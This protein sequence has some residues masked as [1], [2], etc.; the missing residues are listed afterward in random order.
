MKVS[1]I[2]FNYYNGLHQRFKELFAKVLKDFDENAIHG[3]RVNMKKQVAFFRLLAGIDP[4]FRADKA[5]TLFF[6]IFKN[7]GAIRKIHI[8]K[9]ILTNKDLN[10]NVGAD[11]IE[12]LE[13]KLAKKIKQYLEYSNVKDLKSIK[14]NNRSVRKRIHKIST[15]NLKIGLGEYFSKLIQG[16]K[17]LSEI[18]TVN[19]EAFHNL[20][21]MLKELF[22]NLGL[23]NQLFKKE[24]LSPD[25]LKYLDQL[26]TALGEWHDIHLTLKHFSALEKPDFDIID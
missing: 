23:I 21:K 10:I 5:E 8:E 11:V 6:R 18:C 4:K 22:Y 7:A 3:F 26:Q 9:N 12:K 20:R 19:E 25:I 1:K 24:Q 15:Y 16:L 17:G 14:K 13:K 2:I